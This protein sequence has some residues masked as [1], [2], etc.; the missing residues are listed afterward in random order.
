MQNSN[1]PV[2]ILEEYDAR[3]PEHK[4]QFAELNREW[5]RKFFYVEPFDEEM[6]A[7]P[8]GLVLAKGG[9][10]F[11]ARAE[12]EVVGT[13]SLLPMEENVYEI[14][15]MG[16]TALWQQHKIG[17]KLL[18]ACLE[19]AKTIK[20]KKLFIVSNTALEPAI[21]LYR[22][23]GFNDSPEIRHGHYARGNIT[24]ERNVA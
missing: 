24:L 2:I 21:R 19:R 16:V 15:K 22:R 10:I 11:F 12:G 23:Y 6:F 5:L 13:C 8:E 1:S 9:V 17:E 18:V 14:A 3:K 4:S 7:D 20:A